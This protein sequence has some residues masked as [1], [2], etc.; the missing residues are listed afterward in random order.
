M[1]VV[2]MDKKIVVGISDRDD[3]GYRNNGSNYGYRYD[4]MVTMNIIIMMD[5]I[6]VVAVDSN[7]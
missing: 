3:D 6:S 7:G 5:D 2:M 4:V 1:Q